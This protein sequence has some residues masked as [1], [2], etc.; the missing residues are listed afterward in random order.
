MSLFYSSRCLELVLMSVIELYFGGKMTVGRKLYNLIPMYISMDIIKVLDEM[1]L[2]GIECN[3]EEK[4]RASLPQHHSSCENDFVEDAYTKL[5]IRLFQLI[6]DLLWALTS[7]MAIKITQK[8]DKRCQTVLLA[9]LYQCLCVWLQTRYWLQFPIF[10][11]DI[12]W[13][14]YAS[15]FIQHIAKR[16]DK[17]STKNLQPN[18]IIHN[19]RIKFICFILA[20][21]NALRRPITCTQNDPIKKS[22]NTRINSVWM[23]AFSI[24][25]FNLTYFFFGHNQT[26]EHS[27]SS[28]ISTNNC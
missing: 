14:L 28:T 26:N 21:K 7:T 10:N 1:S 24:I 25:Y 18:V 19:K 5:S 12:W 2:S 8:A 22:F 4:L 17:K 13:I 20:K 3:V 23:R 15:Y 11:E 9:Q 16:F 6:W 27:A